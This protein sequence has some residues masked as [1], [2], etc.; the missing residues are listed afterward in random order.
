VRG[1]ALRLS[2]RLLAR[3][4]DARITTGKPYRVRIGRFTDRTAAA[5]LVAKLKSEKT[6]A[7]IVEAEHK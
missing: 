6:V 5:E 4:Y 1:D 3:G 7:I 2:A